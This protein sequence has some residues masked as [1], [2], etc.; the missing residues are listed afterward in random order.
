MKPG[1]IAPSRPPRGGDPAAPARVIPAVAR[2]VESSRSVA[3]QGVEADVEDG[4]PGR[5]IHPGLLGLK[6]SALAKAGSPSRRSLVTGALA[7]AA[8]AFGPPRM[9]RAIGDHARLRFARLH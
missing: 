2:A 4:M 5:S 3:A 8:A 7:A 9:A 6:D 1:D